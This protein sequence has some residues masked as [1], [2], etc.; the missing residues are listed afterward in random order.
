MPFATGVKL[1]SH[2]AGS[3]PEEHAAEGPHLHVGHRRVPDVGPTRCVLLA[4]KS[5]KQLY[6]ERSPTLKLSVVSEEQDCGQAWRS[7][8]LEYHPAES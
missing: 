6:A 5:T 2:V 8:K 7:V 1:S 4:R 3:T